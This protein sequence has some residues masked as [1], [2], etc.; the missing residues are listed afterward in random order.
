MTRH[1]KPSPWRDRRQVEAMQERRR[2]YEE[3]L[4]SE[5][6]HFASLTVDCEEC[7]HRWINQV[8]G[9]PCIGCWTN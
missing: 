9:C 7:G 8:E 4:E 1:E 2:L 5:H 3:S 6:T